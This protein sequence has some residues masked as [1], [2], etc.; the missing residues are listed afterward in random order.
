[1]ARLPDWN[2]TEFKIVMNSYGLSI[3]EVMQK[4][5]R[6]RLEVVRSRDAIEIVIEGIDR[7]H[8]GK[9]NCGLLSKM[10]INILKEKRHP[11]RCPKCR[12]EF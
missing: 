1:M 7:Y 8:L 10:M 11:I 5:R 12:I 9:E 2:E 4:L 6:C 3:E